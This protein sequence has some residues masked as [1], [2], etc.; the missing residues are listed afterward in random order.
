MTGFAPGSRAIAVLGSG[1]AAA[2]AAGGLARG[3]ADVVLYHRVFRGEKPC[4]GAVP[5]TALSGLP[6][7]FR[8]D[9][10]PAVAPTAARVESL[11]G[12]VRVELSGLSILRRGSLD[13]ALL[14]AAVEA[15]ARPVTERVTRIEPGA[16]GV[17][18]EVGGRRVRHDALVAADGARSLARRAL[19]LPWA[20]ESVGLGASLAGLESSE[21]V[22]SFPGA[23]DAYLW[24][25]PRPGG[26]SVGVGH[27]RSSLAD[28]TA[29]ALLEAFVARHLGADALSAPGA[30]YR[31]PIPVYSERTAG[32]LSHAARRRVLLVGDAA[33]VAD[34]ITREGIRPALATG[35][36]A[37]DALLAGTPQRYPG[38]VE[39][40]LG[41][42]GRRALRLRDL[43]FEDGLAE[44]M[45]PVCRLLP[46][47]RGVLADLLTCKRGY[48]GLRRALLQG[49][50]GWS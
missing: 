10:L 12:A 30:R 34:P 41:S 39:V 31:Y 14:A 20:E 9:G 48:R 26:V 8:T 46:G 4:G 18:L 5:S 2:V 16:T 3:G 28:G 35:R 44:W 6:A 11:H 50:V 43:F 29:R 37:A 33:G 19:G 40:E 27:S 15:G 45:P 24:I 17:G 36:W 1:P 42:E 21:L 49:A 7:G 38:L 32:D 13:A 47:V 25:F 22:L 23:G